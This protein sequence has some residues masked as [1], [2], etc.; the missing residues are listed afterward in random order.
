[1]TQL[2]KFNFLLFSCTNEIRVYRHKYHSSKDA[3]KKPRSSE[4]ITLI[5]IVLFL[6]YRVNEN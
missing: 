1:M 6:N 5:E 2:Y 4:L 3:F